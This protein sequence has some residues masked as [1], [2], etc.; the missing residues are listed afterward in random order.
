MNEDEKVLEYEVENDN[1]DMFLSVSMLIEIGKYY[2]CEDEYEPVFKKLQE[3][4][5]GLDLTEFRNMLI[6]EYPPRNDDSE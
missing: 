6:K 3:I 5:P 1:S 2:P 4:F